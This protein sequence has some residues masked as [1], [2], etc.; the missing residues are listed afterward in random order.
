MKKAYFLLGVIGLILIAAIV[1]RLTSPEDNWVCK[2]GQ[3]LKHGNPS[4]ARPTSSCPGGKEKLVGSDRDE[5][6]CVASAGYSWCEIKQK[7]L[8]VWEE[9]CEIESASSTPT[10][11]EL[12]ISVTDE[13]LVLSPK[14]N[15]LIT[16]PLK[17]S[18]QARG[19]WFFE[20]SMPVKL[21]SDDN[22]LIVASSTQALDDWMTV[23]P[24][25]FSSSLVFSTNATSGYLII[26][27]DNPSGLPQNDNSIKVPVRF[28]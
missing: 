24:V 21:F 27:K 20:A 18:G 3:W 2:D 11:S 12:P 22:Q 4:A 6:N 23:K 25:R 7:C 1:L 14:Q 9:K 15:E 16:S 26:A 8:R 5:H 13:I 28:K 19:N 10:E 17:I